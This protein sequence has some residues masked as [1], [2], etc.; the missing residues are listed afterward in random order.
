MGAAI[1]LLVDQPQVSVS[2]LRALVEA[3]AGDLPDVLAPLVEDRRANPVLFDRRTFPDLLSLQGDTGGRAIF[4]KFPPHHLPWQDAML[5]QDIDTLED[6][7][8]LREA[9]G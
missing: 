1:F 8:R 3:H 2:L 5:L 7:Q 9:A 4:A 6:Y